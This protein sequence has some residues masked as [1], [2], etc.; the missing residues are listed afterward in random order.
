MKFETNYSVDYSERDYTDGVDEIF[1]KRWSPRSFQKVDISP[2]LLNCI[3]DAA[4]WAPSS[5]NEQPWQFITSSGTSD[6]NM[7]LH[8]LVEA[9]Q[10]WAKNASLLGFIIA[11]KYFSSNQEPNSCAVFDCGSAW[12]SLTLQARR[13]GLYTHGMGGIKKEE[14][15]RAFSL[16]KTDVEVIC[17]FAIGVIDLP[18]KLPDDLASMEQPSGRKVLDEIWRQ[19]TLS[20]TMK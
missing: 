12:M 20:F 9:N 15:Y 4:R 13:F 18:D 1:Y 2:A 10:V 14:V 5:Y 16:S 11:K 19:G 6:F 17:G 8:L 7:F 3:F